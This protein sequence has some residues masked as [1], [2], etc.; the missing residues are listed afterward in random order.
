MTSEAKVTVAIPTYNRA[1][2]LKVSLESVLA[3]DYPDFRVVVLDNASSDDTEAVVRSLA[4]RDRRVTYI[5]NETN[6]GMLRNLNR[7]IE[8]NSSP[9]FN[10]F[11]DD[12]V[13]LPGFIRESVLSLDKHPSA[14]FSF[15]MAR[16]V[17][18]NGG[19]LDLQSSGD[20]PDGVINGL[21]YIDLCI[22]WHG[23]PI[24]GSTVLMRAAS[25]AEVG[26]FDSPHTKTTFD[27]NL[28]FR[29]AARFDIAYIRK[30]LVHI[31]VHPGQETEFHWR[32]SQ[33][34]GPYGVI[35]E[36]I[37]AIAYLL[38]SAR[39]QDSSYRGWLAER[40]LALN[41]RQSEYMHPVVPSMYHT[42]MERLELATHEIAKLIP[43]G[44]TF[45]LVDEAQWGGEG[46]E[47]RYAIPFV[48]RDGQYWGPPADDETAIREL[49]R[50]RRSGAKFMVVGWPAF[51]WLDYY[52]GL[53]R[54]LRSEFRYVLKNSR[55]IVFDLQPSHD[56]TEGCH[57]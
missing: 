13:M 3:Q 46:V 50:L 42:W 41:A 31:R 53:H 4:D 55:L 29:L 51:W 8:V 2:L 35:S 1:Q 52:T 36:C 43:P 18:F 23:C 15:T 49:E 45:I 30:E 11:H 17:D 33:G 44:D 39:A 56:Y 28:Y 7:A 9:Y 26:L 10:I 24:N 22:A 20:V 6:I 37:D 25:L 34:T 32:S 12:D 21:E 14:V 57:D 38:Q 47:S 19:L 16:Y 40:L 54:Y 27:L 48:E 5:R